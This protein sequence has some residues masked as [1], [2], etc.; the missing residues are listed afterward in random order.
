MNKT[1]Y[2]SKSNRVLVGVCGGVAEY[3]GWD[4]S[5]VRIGVAIL[6]AFSGL[7][8]VAYIVAALVVPE[9]PDDF[10]DVVDM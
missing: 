4:P 7:G 6:S 2:K 8:I 10:N 9:E 5:L 1:L 3:F